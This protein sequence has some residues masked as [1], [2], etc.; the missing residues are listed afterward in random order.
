MSPPHP[1]IPFPFLTSIS[2]LWGLSPFLP[3]ITTYN[4]LF[5]FICL[6]L[7]GERVLFFK[8]V[9][10]MRS[11]ILL[12]CLLFILQFSSVAQ[13]CL[14]LRP[15]ESQHARPP[16]PSPTPGVYPNSCLLLA[17]GI[18]SATQYIT[19]NFTEWVKKSMEACRHR[20][21]RIYAN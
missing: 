6:F 11:W 2:T 8:S 14:T 17:L 18:A 4:I 12:L 7:V 13:S 9:N 10:F 3:P 15:H 21:L 1:F 16:C 5:M 19:P 20:V